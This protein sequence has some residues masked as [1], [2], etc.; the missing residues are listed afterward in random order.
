VESERVLFDGHYYRT[1]EA[2][3][4]PK[5]AHHIPIWLGTFGP[6]GLALTGRLA[7][8]W[9]P[10]LDLAPP[11]VAIKMR[12][13]IMSA[14]R[15]AGRTPTEITCAYN[16]PVRLSQEPDSD[17]AVVSGPPEAVAARL[18]EFVK[19]GFTAINFILLGPGEEEQRNRIASE[20]IPA[21]RA[22][23]T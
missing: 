18:A 9:I 13:Q 22:M 4:E 12:E 15:A 21:A 19:I 3:L 6:R 17:Q 7:D 16:L 5:P 20:V 23:A 11:D 10:S 14:A 2:D 1:E 8:G